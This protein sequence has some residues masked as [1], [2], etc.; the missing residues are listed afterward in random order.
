MAH[1]PLYTP[2]PGTELEASV[3]TLLM[4]EPWSSGT[5]MGTAGCEKGTTTQDHSYQEELWGSQGA[6]LLAPAPL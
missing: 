4:N 3:L 1:P 5:Y 2:T 6:L